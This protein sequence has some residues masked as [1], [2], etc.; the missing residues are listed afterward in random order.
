MAVANP[1]ISVLM[2]VY[3]GE[4][5]LREAVESILNQ[6]FTDFE[7]MIVDDGSTDGT[8]AILQSYNDPR[9]VLLRNEEN[10]GLTRSLNMGLAVARGEYIARQ[11]ADDVS[12]PERL[13]KQVRF[14]DKHPEIVLVSSDVEFID[15]EGRSL[16]RSQR[17]CDPNLVAWYLL[18]YNHVAGHSQVMFRH[19]PVMDLGGY[20]EARRYSQDY[21]LWLRL[22]KLGDI[23]ILPDVMLQW[24]H[25]GENISVKKYSEQE[26]YSLADARYSIA[27]LLGEELSLAEV[28]E[29]RGFWLGRFPDSRRVGALHAKLK[30]LYRAFLQQR[31]QQGSSG[32]ELSRQLRILIGQQFFHWVRALSTRHRLFS[33]L[34]VSLYAFAWHPLGALDCWLREI[35]NVLL[36]LYALWFDRPIKR[37]A[38]RSL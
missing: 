37:I 9:I 6:T 24:R 23:A 33:K 2:S 14:L 3:D 5:Y 8:W 15:S 4:R 32:P 19:K 21:E 1:K 36:R 16:G 18:F 25:H 12:L 30:W 10:T 11:D 13:E 35:W 34:K 22:V 7:F 31:A 26:A 27:Q 38:N 28:A 17:A 29:L 20:S